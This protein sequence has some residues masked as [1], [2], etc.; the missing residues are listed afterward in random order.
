VFA[1]RLAPLIVMSAAF[2]AV[3]LVLV[4]FVDGARNPR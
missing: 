2:T 1:N 3:V 4:P